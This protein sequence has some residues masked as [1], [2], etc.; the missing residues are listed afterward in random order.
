[1]AGEKNGEGRMLAVERRQRILEMLAASASVRVSE[2]C[3]ACDVSAVT[4]RGDLDYLE[5]EGLLRRTHGGA[6]AISDYVSARQS[7]TDRRAQ[8]AKQ[9]IGRRA[10]EL[11]GAGETILVGSGSTVLEFVKA[12]RDKPSL[13]IIGNDVD[14]LAYAAQHLPDATV[15]ATGGQFDRARRHFFGPF[16]AASLADVILDKV[17]LSADSF[18]PELG[19][20]AEFEMT[21][22]AKVEFMRHARKCVVLMDSS[23]VSR[24]LSAMRF[25]RPEEVDVVVMDAD[26][27]GVVRASCNAGEKNVEVIE[28]VGA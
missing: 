8:R 21:A 19:F 4:A 1:M 27:D 26:P 25:A 2:I 24:G 17:F 5:G 7:E 10:A 6:V 3:R 18:D 22:F 14:V 11:V 20:L 23:K 13:T 12:L 15:V 9:A 28:A 16:L